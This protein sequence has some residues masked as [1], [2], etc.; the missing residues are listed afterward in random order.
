MK[1]K[2][3]SVH[4]DADKKL[5]DFI[6]GKLD[7]VAQNSVDIIDAEVILKLDKSS[8]TENKVVEIKLLIPGND[9]FAKKQCKSFE[10]ATDQAVDA[11][12]TQ[13]KKYREKFKSTNGR[14][15]KLVTESDEF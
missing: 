6:Q 4:F 7:K 8:N 15:A 13:M 12:K 1:A 14:G 2:I 5:I 9:L 11:L 3:Q 10:E